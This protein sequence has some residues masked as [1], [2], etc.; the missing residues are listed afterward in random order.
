[1]TSPDEPFGPQRSLTDHDV[2]I[3]VRDGTVLRATVT[4]PAGDACVLTLPVL[5][6]AR[7]RTVDVPAADVPTA[8]A[9]GPSPG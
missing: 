5:E 9:T 1:M 2:P 7:A 6:R 8:H 4:R 3:P